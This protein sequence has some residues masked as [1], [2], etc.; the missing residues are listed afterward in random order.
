MSNDIIPTPL[1]ANPSPLIVQDDEISLG[2][3]F[4]RILQ[5]KWWVL[6]IYTVVVSLVALYTAAQAPLFEATSM[7]HVEGE[8]PGL[9]DL[10]TM[11]F[12]G[13]SS[14]ET[15]V[16]IVRSRVIAGEVVRRLQEVGRNPLTGG[17]FHLLTA[18]EDDP[19]F[20]PVESLKSNLLRVSTVGPDV[21]L[22]NITVQS[23]LPAEAMYLANVYADEYEA[24]D[25]R[26]SRQGATSLREFF[27]QQV[28]RLDS[29]VRVEEGQFIEYLGGQSVVA[30]ET[31]AQVLVQQ[32]QGLQQQVY[33][34]EAE[35]RGAQATV[36]GLE[37]EI[38]RLQPS[39]RGQLR[40]ANLAIITRLQQE[41][42]ENEAQL[43]IFY[44]RT[45]SDR[46]S[47]SPGPG[48]V[49]LR[50]NLA[51]LQ[52][53]LD[54]AAS[55]ISETIAGGIPVGGGESAALGNRV[56]ELVQEA[57]TAR[58]QLS[59]TTATLS[60]LNDAIFEVRRRINQLP[61]QNVYQERYMRSLDQWQESLVEFQ[62]QQQFAQAAEQSEVGEV[63]VV[64][65][66]ILPKEPVS[67]RVSL[68][69]LLSAIL[70]GIG[71]IGFVLLL[72][73]LDAKIRRP[74][75]VRAR[76]L[77]VLTVIPDMQRTIQEDFG[78][79]KTVDVDGTMYSTS[80][81]TLLNPLSP[82]T[83]SFRRLRTSIEYSRPDNPPRVIQVTSPG[84]GE[85][86][87]TVASNLAVAL[88]QA[89]HRTVYVDADMRRPTAHKIMGTSREPGL[90][91]LLFGE[92]ERVLA[93]A[94]TQI[95]GLSVIPTGRSTSV[96]GELLGSQKM[97]DAIQMLLTK[98]DFV[99]LDT[100]P[101]LAVN[102]A[103]VVSLVADYRLLVVSTGDTSLADLDR[104]VD[105][106]SAVGRKTD[107]A[108]IN[109]FDA[110]RAYGYNYGSKGYGYGVYQY[111]SNV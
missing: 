18:R 100:P 37:A 89:G 56:A 98:Y 17:P 70:G 41:I 40:N 68:N 94:Q 27:D 53:R 92:E 51:V 111:G 7:V 10:A 24:Y 15:Q 105:A 82:I 3:L 50:E 47:S 66:A 78:G 86:K 87:S 104:A 85:G 25:R 69:L 55:E 36:S 65:Y 34:V 35:R 79:N 96:P 8:D 91:E 48:V 84:P 23:E 107:G 74:D 93:L 22:I 76:N 103:A 30:P 32:I 99:V 97:R 28:Q 21:D 31:E 42:A 61:T 75:D 95:D 44:A 20:D 101:L 9:A 109:R 45:P 29:I 110:Q 80:L 13:S 60:V 67:P 90:V 43:E 63:R 59:A 58:I 39:V 46:T 73:A 64:D 49:E 81:L 108:V 54:Q 1:P 106:L 62:R 71:G 57:V 11:G 26:V 5:G 12:G 72:S 6:A 33:Q 16:H 83:E 14:I 88:A 52:Q 102:D 4:E 38:D 77:N 2:D 19:E